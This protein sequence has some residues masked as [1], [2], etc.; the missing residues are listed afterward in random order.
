MQPSLQRETARLVRSWM[1]HDAEML[2]GYL[3][4]S[5][6]D[7]R[8]NLQ[9]LL[10]RHFLLR[11][12]TG[13][14]F[15]P[16]M[17]HECRFAAA[18]NWLLPLATRAG[19]T[20]ELAAVLHALR[21]GAD[22]AEGIEIPRFLSRTFALLPQ[23]DPGAMAGTADAAAARLRPRPATGMDAAAVIPNYIESFLS[24]A[25]FEGDKLLPHEPTL[26]TFLQLWSAA[27]GG[28]GEAE[29]E[30]SAA[31]PRWRVLE[32]ACGSANDYRFLAACGIAR[33]IDY[34]GF[35]LC[36]KNIENARALFPGVDF[37]TG[38][39]FE[40]AGPDNAY[41]L[42][43]LHDLFEHLSPEGIQ[44]AA[45]E[46]CRVTRRG[47]CIGFFD[48]D[49]IPSHQIRPLEEYHGN[50]LSMSQMRA[51]FAAGGFSAQV[52]HVGTFL[53]RQLGCG[54]THNPN[55][56]TFVLEAMPPRRP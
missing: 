23:A 40:I 29:V 17:E 13:G 43:F 51:L 37:A 26:N 3:V 25:R 49:E 10:S 41:D 47:I 22:N 5:V 1:R 12:L 9:S 19:G 31:S 4:A 33:R 20:E 28:A 56:Y 50:T 35:D 21:R 39:V 8:I 24:N 11:A 38:N 30:S 48:M 55:A 16:L 53:R 7:P 27:L 34:S 52:L 15:A 44:T 45:K 42:C 36:P 6:E 32:P 14:R 54:Q 46:I 2:R 18:M